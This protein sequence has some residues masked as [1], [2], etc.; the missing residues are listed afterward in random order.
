[1]SKDV[2]YSFR[3]VNYVLTLIFRGSVFSFGNKVN[4]SL[5]SLSNKQRIA[6]QGGRGLAIRYLFRKPMWE[7]HPKENSTCCHLSCNLLIKTILSFW[8]APSRTHTPNWLMSWNNYK[9][10]RSKLIE[11]SGKLAQLA[12]LS[13]T[14]R[15]L[16]SP[17]LPVN[18]LRVIKRK[19]WSFLWPGSIPEKCGHHMSWKV[20]SEAF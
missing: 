11:L 15:C 7:A 16:K 17:S 20:L 10:K 14:M 9:Q 8:L 4:R 1:M 12:R 2:K 5:C 13:V 6:H 3:I 18:P 19:K